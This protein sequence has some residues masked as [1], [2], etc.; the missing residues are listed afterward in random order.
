M[1][2]T[3]PI[4][5]KRFLVDNPAVAVDQRMFLHGFA[6]KGAATRLHAGSGRIGAG[7]PA[8]ALTG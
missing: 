6:G 5:V 3:K 7:P 4:S 1:L 8:A 2:A